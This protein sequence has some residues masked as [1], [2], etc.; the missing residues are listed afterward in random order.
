M[1]TY[2]QR[3]TLRRNPTCRVTALLLGFGLLVTCSD[4]AD[5]A[6]QPTA[7]DAAPAAVQNSAEPVATAV[8]PNAEFV[9]EADRFADI[10]VLR[11]RVPGFDVLADPQKE[12]LYY[13]S[14]AALSGRD[15]MYDQNFKHNLRIRRTL[16]EIVKHYP[17]DKTSAE[18]AEFIVYTKQVW[19]SNGIHH[20][21]SYLKH[22]PGFDQAYFAELVN[23]SAA[24]AS[25]PL[26]ENQNVEQLIAE[27]SPIL[28]DPLVAPKKV[29][30]ADGVDKIV[31]SS[32]NFY[33]GVTE[34]EVLD[35]YA[36]KA[37]RND[38][39]P[40]SYGLNS[41][42][43]KENGVITERVWKIGGMYSPAL[44][45][46]VYWLERAIT[47]AENGKQKTALELLVSYYRSGD[48]SDFDAYNIAWVQDVDST[49]DV[50]NGFIETYND[51]LGLRGSFESVVSFRDEEATL[52]ISAIGERAQWFEDNSPI[53][54]QHK[55][56]DVVGING[57]VITVVMESGDASPSTPIGINLPN[58]NWIRAQHGSKS[59]SLSNIVG[60]YNATP[61]QALEEFAYTADDVSRSRE[62]AEQAGD[63][64]TDMH[65]VIGH[66][67]GL[68]NPGVGTPR[69]TLRQYA[70]T[71]EEGRADLVALYYMMDPMLI[72][73]G[74]M[75]SLEVGY[76]EYDS[77][78]RNGAMT[79]LY[80]IQ[81]G[82]LV[83]EAHMRNRQLISL[84]AYEQGL[85]ENVIER[86]QR[87]GKTYFVVNDY[88]KLRVIFGR[89]LQELQRIT[90]EGDFEAARALV[91]NYGTQVDRELHA[92]VLQR[93][94][95]LNVAPYSGFINPRVV[96]D[97]SN[98]VVS[99]VRME[100]PDDFLAQMLE[101]AENYSFLPTD[102]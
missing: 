36:A 30:T 84:W 28:F 76:S 38:A 82:G 58:A 71:I 34:Q 87:D 54:P 48:L 91:E 43:V 68:I 6:S 89:L 72:E 52:R 49:V 35:F 62:H 67:S 64:H 90:S 29:N 3:H 57:K 69:E 12:L 56:A 65:E 100:Y 41:K 40:P 14:Q 32:V 22:V 86:V 66:A 60:A 19:F 83:E 77:Y 97:E 4:P 8:D 47:V 1:N 33:E 74:V 51:P 25:F 17:G 102:N 63:L 75:D 15:I 7:V 78:I 18:F 101:Y 85:P 37:D 16:E 99:N 79:Q 11:Y 2:L 44:E 50:I 23:A 88:Q 53:L 21:Y 92:E 45:Q 73:L 24:A 31:T 61:G 13:L 9:Y 81:P 93:Y 27:L 59:V 10:R 42:L 20:H 96:A 98:G 5:R 94:A 46:V 70:S 55:K 26:R 39:T 95:P 80:R